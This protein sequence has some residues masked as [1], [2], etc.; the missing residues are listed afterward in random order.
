MEQF[1]EPEDYYGSVGCFENESTGPDPTDWDQQMYYERYPDQVKYLEEWEYERDFER[2][3]QLYPEST[4]RLQGFVEEECDKMEYEGSRMFDAYPDKMMLRKLCEEIAERAAQTEISEDFM[5]EEQIKEKKTEI[6]MEEEKGTVVVSDSIEDAESIPEEGDEV[7]DSM[8]LSSLE[9][10]CSSGKCPKPNPGPN[11]PGPN[12]G[13]YPPGPNPGPYPPGSNPGPYPPGPNPKPYPPGPNPKPY[14]PG[15]NHR[16]VPQ[17]PGNQWMDLIEVLL[18]NEIYQR[19][20]RH[21]RCR[22]YW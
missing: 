4:K 6:I 12:P 11:P 22:R 8:N 20:C 14:P 5:K 21:K 13:P 9:A 7:E 1:Y 3:K 15:P 2:I 18:Y 10:K 19:R 16:P 17:K